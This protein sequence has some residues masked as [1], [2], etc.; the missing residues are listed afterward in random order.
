MKKTNRQTI[1]LK[2]QY[3]QLKIIPYEPHKNLGV[4]SGAPQG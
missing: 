4:I 3:R 2:K 1:V